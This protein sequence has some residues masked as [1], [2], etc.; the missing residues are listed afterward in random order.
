MIRSKVPM[1]DLARDVA[2][3]QDA[4]NDAYN[5]L[6]EAGLLE[7][8]EAA[9]KT[10]LMADEV[11]RSIAVFV[12][13]LSD[14]IGDAMAD[15]SQP[16]CGKIIHRHRRASR[17]KWEKDDLLRNVLDTKI[18]D[19]DGEI[20]DETPLDKVLHVWNLGAPRLKAL[21]ARGIEAD[22]FCQTEWRDGWTLSDYK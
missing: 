9:Y 6:T 2:L 21:E 1:D 8:A 7:D 10:Y 12:D 3:A 16:M 4:I 19:A 5:A 20:V 15:S 18:A 17:T 22:Q 11:K 13:L 14:K